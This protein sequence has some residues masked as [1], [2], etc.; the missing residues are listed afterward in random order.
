MSV[1]ERRGERLR[2]IVRTGALLCALAAGTAV[3]AAAQ[4]PTASGAVSDSITGEPLADVRVTFYDGTNPVLTTTTDA[5]GRFLVA[6][7]PGF[8]SVQ[9]TRLDYAS[10]VTPA[11]RVA[12]G[13]PAS[14]TVALL[15]RAL[16]LNPVVVSASRRLEMSLDAPASVS[17]LE[18]PQ[19]KQRVALTVADYI[20]QVTGV[21]FAR[22]G[23]TQSEV[24]VRGF[25]NIASGSLLV[26]TDNRYAAVPS[27]QINDY[28]AIPLANADIARIEIVR[29]PGSA[30]YGPNSA[31]GVL[32]II[33][34]APLDAL[35]TDLALTAGDRELFQGSFRHSGHLASGIGLK[36]SSQYQRG[37]EWTYRDPVE[38]SNRLV[39]LSQG[40]EA[41]TLRIGLRDSMVERWSGE[42]QLEMRPGHEWDWT[43]SAGLNY[44]AHTIQLSPLGAAQVRNSTYYYLQSRVSHK[45]FFAQAFLN[46]NDAGGTYLVR[47]G[48][49]V[50]DQSLELVGQI[51][52]AVTA[53][54]RGVLTY[55]MDARRTVPKTEGTITGRNEAND[56]I[57]ELG[58]YLH[59]ETP[60]ARPLTFVSAI[61]VD[62]NSRLPDPV[63]SPR[64]ALIFRPGARQ[65]IRLTYNRA[66]STP[67]TN[68]LFLD[69]RGATL[70]TPIPM[71]VR[72][73]G[74]PLDGFT[75]RRDCGGLCMRSPYTPAAAGG[76][77]TYLPLDGTVVW[78]TLVDSLRSKS[79][80]DLSGIPAPTSTDV[81]TRLQ[82]LDIGSQRFVPVSGQDDIPALRPTISSAVELGYRAILSDAFEMEL[83]AYYGWK[84]DFISGERTETPNAFY[85]PA[86]LRDYLARYLP[87]DSAQFY[88]NIVSQIP[89]GTVTPVE[90]RDPW[91]ILVTYRNYGRLGYWGGDASFTAKIMPQLAAHVGF[92]W[93]SRN[94]FP[95][96]S[97]AGPDTVM[98]NAPR[99][100]GSLTI[101]YGDPIGGLT[102]QL[103]GRAV[104]TFPVRSGVYV[105]TVKGYA[106]FDGNVGYRLPFMPLVTMTLAADNI[107]DHIHQ[108]FIGVPEIGRMVSLRAGATF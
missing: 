47:T 42:T 71:D 16:A 88:S 99:R 105:G 100:R 79:P 60:L 77:G 15:P 104:E 56:N 98:L 8:Y 13:A 59:A 102:V 43:T 86:T 57:D 9:F 44:A 76:P 68:N 95:V 58:A 27:L 69:L 37:L 31:N 53:L 10:H 63:F 49:L 73:V 17:V 7:D 40:A 92:S 74:V 55:G 21:D 66:F 39:A 61:R 54:G 24:V 23:L 94:T 97:S 35:G 84:S 34:R 25:N 67:N 33:T 19:L 18:R 80:Y 32:H 101:S 64:A 4:Q 72:L 36:V 48:D 75:F 108:E 78:T 82:R 30:L 90:A 89:L 83:D 22:T 81:S 52:N 87:A 2:T 14:L 62:Y 20:P 26:L 41:D 1:I 91:D 65:A 96:T 70:P 5:D 38:V 29:G 12:A 50:K 6:L 45:R 11:V 103:R 85:D 46:T 107:F 51:Q 93:T 106:V 28:A 3:A